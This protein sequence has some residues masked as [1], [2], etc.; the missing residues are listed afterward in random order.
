MYAVR[1]EMRGSAVVVVVMV[2]VEVEIGCGTLTCGENV[3]QS[4]SMR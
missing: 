4:D 3:E 1:G 2:V